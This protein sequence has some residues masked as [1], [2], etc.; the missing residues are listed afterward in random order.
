MS[1]HK[2]VPKAP[3]VTQKP[4]PRTW[5]IPARKHKKVLRLIDG[6]KKKDGQLERYELFTLLEKIV[7]ET[8]GVITQV[9]LRGAT[10]YL[11]EVL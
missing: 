7:P 11:E 8:K 10:P 3:R 1:E 4:K 2:G 6:L 5:E 9:R